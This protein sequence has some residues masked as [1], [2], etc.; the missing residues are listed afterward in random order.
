VSDTAFSAVIPNLLPFRVPGTIEAVL[1]Y[2]LGINRLEGVYNKLRAMTDE[3]PIAARLLQHLEVTVRTSEKDQDHIPRQGPVLL[4]VNHPF[5]ILEGAVLSTLL[6]RVRPDVKF[7]TNGI[8]QTIPD[9]RERLIAVDPMGGAGAA[10]SNCAGVRQAVEF[11]ADGGLLVIFPAGDVSHF[12]WRERSITDPKWNAG[13]ARLLSIAN[14]RVHDISVLP[15]HVEGSNSLLFQAAGMV[16]PRLRTMMLVRE[17]LNKRGAS[18]AVRIG[19]PIAAEKLLAIPSHE[20]RTEYLRWRTYLLASRNEYKPRTALPFVRSSAQA[21]KLQA[22]VAPA[23]V[24][25]MAREVGA[26]PVGSR[27][28]AAGVLS[29]YLARAHEIPVVLS[30]IGR[31]RE[32]TFRTAGE[33]TG[34]SI[35]LDSFDQDYLHLFLWNEKKQEIAGAYRLAGTD[36]VRG[37]YTADLFRYGNEFL[38]RMGP[39]LE[40]GR[41]FVRLEYQKGFAPLLLLW[42][43]IGGYV[44]QNPRYKI[45]FGPVSIS[46]QYHSVSRQLMVSFLERYASLQGWAGLVATRNPFR[47]RHKQ[48]AAFPNAA[49]DLD[50]LSAVVSDLEPGQAGVPVL[51]RQYL[52]LGGKLLGFNVDPQFADALDGLILVDL[53]KTEPKLLQRYLGKPEAAQFLAFHRGQDGT[54]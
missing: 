32:V 8:L 24:L 37:L 23:D 48:S 35:D 34:K 43:G 51:L 12:Q 33:G 16:H 1:G 2:T 54:Q 20:E 53:T 11:L 5:G 22:I 50:D 13:I 10:R 52:K 46:N 4:A 49:F 15:V 42:K 9:L 29:A 21:P 28:T 18:V 30:E 19:S 17:L 41:S 14:R 26:L 25:A 7:L 47:S 6:A 31:L 38:N 44:A 36:M 45:L 3:A 39:A 40:L 27:L